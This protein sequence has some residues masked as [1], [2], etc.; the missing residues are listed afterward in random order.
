MLT[1]WKIFEVTMI[2]FFLWCIRYYWGRR[3]LYQMAR[4]RPGPL[5]LPLIGS[6]FYLMRSPKD[7]F[8][9]MFKFAKQ[10]KSPT[11]AWL[12][13]M[14]F[15]MVWDPKSL[16]VI[17]NDTNTLGKHNFYKFVGNLIGLGLIMHEVPKWRRHRRTILP[18]F[19]RNIL[20]AFTD[21]FARH[22][23]ILADEL[24]ERIG[25]R[26]FDIYRYCSGCVN[27]FIYETGLGV[28]GQSQSSKENYISCLDR[29]KNIV[30]LRINN[31][32]YHSD[33]I[34]N[35]SPLSREYKKI[36]EY[37]YTHVHMAIQQHNHTNLSNT[38]LQ[39]LIA[40][41]KEDPEF[42]EKDL[43][44]EINAFV[45][46]GKDTTTLTMCYTLIML[47]MHPD[48]QKKLYDEVIVG[49][50]DLLDRVLRETLRIFPPAP[51][52]SRKVDADIALDSCTIPAGSSVA[53][54]IIAL[55]RDP[56]VWPEPLKFDPD[57]F[58]GERAR[59]PYDW[60]PFSGG[61]RNCVGRQYAF[62]ALKVI[63]STLVKKYEFSTEYKSVEDIKFKPNLVLEPVKGFLVSINL[64]K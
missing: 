51:C 37:I 16:K 60:L 42:T 64:R 20:K 27:D 48:V 44:D 5:A 7:A 34:F 6:A 55:H 29:A 19:N 45:I 22:A 10:F 26:S 13:P 41:T 36:C 57:R 3:R 39:A 53:I 38:F 56:E 31:I 40:A 47:G 58:L 12:G 50:E 25:Q 8:D 24:E 9:T 54:A 62:M 18:I 43:Q 1:E 63:I 46:A 61:P 33:W 21:V 2:V 11:P 30:F 59:E 23:L 17:L 35:L 52:I 14:L 4:Q 28:M 49:G 15:F 32:F